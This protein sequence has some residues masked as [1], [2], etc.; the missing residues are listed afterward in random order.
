MFCYRYRKGNFSFPKRG[1]DKDEKGHFNLQ[2]QKS[3]VKLAK[4]TSV[5]CLLFVQVYK[6]CDFLQKIEKMMS[7]NDMHP[8]S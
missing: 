1:G 3:D 2:R 4:T 6:I 5:K 7:K 8:K